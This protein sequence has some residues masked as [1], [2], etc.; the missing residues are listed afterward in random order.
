[1]VFEAQERTKLTMAEFFQASHLFTYGCYD[2][3]SNDFLQWKIYGIL[4]LYCIEY[5][6]HVL[7]NES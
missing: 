3:V 7:E 6:R 4:P 2:H 1:M 5:A